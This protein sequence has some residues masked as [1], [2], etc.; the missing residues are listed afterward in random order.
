MKCWGRNQE[1]ELGDGTTINR[2]LPVDVIGLSGGVIAMQAGGYDA[3]YAM[4][5]TCAITNTGVV[6]CWGVNRAGELGIGGQGPFLATPVNVT[7]LN[8]SI[9]AVEAGGDY[10]CALTVNGGVKCWG[11]NY[12]GKLGDGTT[13]HR[14]QPVTVSGLSSGIS[15]MAAPSYEDYVT[16]RSHSCAVT[17]SG[18]LKCWG[19]NSYGELGDGTTTDRYTPINVSG[20]T[21]GVM[22]ASLGWQH[23]CAVTST[24]GVKCWGRN[25][26]GELG[27]SSSTFN[28][29]IPVD[30]TGLS[31][32]VSVV[33]LGNAFGCVRTTSGA[34]KCWGGNSN[35]QL[36]DGT[37]TSRYTPANVYGLTGGIQ[38]IFSGTYHA[39]ALTNSGGVKCWGENYRGQLGDGTNTDR[40]TPIEVYGLSSGIV[41]VTAGSYHTCALTNSGGLKCWGYNHYGQLGDGTTTDRWTPGDVPGLTSGVIAISAGGDHTCALTNT[42]ILKCWGSYDQGQLGD[43]SV[44]YCTTPQDVLNPCKNI[45]L[46]LL[47]QN[48]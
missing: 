5:H 31:S 3:L 13:I 34:V 1:G 16:R 4:A 6:K 21:S 40:W 46:P 11:N 23:T 48:L 14:L 44:G 32:G 37:T 24:G 25:S 7:G 12:D 38:T 26:S 36:G 47:M 27:I 30:V 45:Y 29:T 22:L 41:M 10:T 15:S 8:E 19:S 28:S 43:G 20:L 39:C 18:G 9:K 17:N 2:S 33:S 35:G 42:G